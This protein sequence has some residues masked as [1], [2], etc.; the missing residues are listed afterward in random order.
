[1]LRK[2][3]ELFEQ[4]NN[5]VVYCHWKSNEHLQEGLDGDTDLDVLLSR[6]D[7]KV[8]SAILRELGFAHLSSQFG[9]R[10][11]NVED[12]V[13]FDADTG[14]LIH[15][16]L[17]YALMTGHK[18]MK[19]YELPWTNECLE[20]RKQDSETGVYTIDPNLELVSLYTRLILKSKSDDTKAAKKASY[21]M[22]CHFLKEITF[23]KSHVDWKKVED[24]A[25]RY[26][27]RRGSEFAKLARHDTLDS[28]GFLSLYQLVSKTM[29]IYSRYHGLSLLCRKY[30]YQVVLPL[31]HR[32]NNKLGC[33]FITHKVSNA[34]GG[35][36]VAFLG[37]DG[38]G[39]STVTEDI[40]KWLTWKIE[41][42]RFYL[43]SGDHY[44]SLLK[45]LISRGVEMKHKSEKKHS[46]NEKVLVK[47]KKNIKS[48]ITSAVV[49]WNMLMIARRAYR[50]MCRAEKYRK[51]GGIVLFDRFPQM[52]FEG[53]SDGPKIVNYYQRTG[54]DFYLNKMMARWEYKYFRRIQQWQPQLVFKLILSPEESLR[55]KPFENLENVIQ[56]HH[57]TKELRFKGAR[58]LD[59]DATQDYKQELLIIK[60][61]IW[62]MLLQNQE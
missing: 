33:M 30:M 24:I 51:K 14:R 11:P 7:E 1:M 10:F 27:G 12:W 55:R 31:R 56:K 13:G 19:E 44:R 15:L 49:S 61:E 9:S 53:I 8:G 34:R 17:H 38:S 43:G 23:I 37:Q 52:Q 57:I 48:F 54:L 18:G 42:D 62:Q 29:N 22:D 16:H 36:S 50:V 41:A 25:I 32:L 46:N 21:K 47:R 35:F 59:V 58:V 5:K 45:K 26:Y 2:C 3:K 6:T 39:K 4:W 20:T 40:R 60:K 28:N